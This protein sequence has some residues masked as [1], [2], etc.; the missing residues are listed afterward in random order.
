M[1]SNTKVT[2]TR[3]SAMKLGIAL[4]RGFKTH[5]QETKNLLFLGL[6]I[7]S[8]IIFV[9][10]VVNV[11]DYIFYERHA[12]DSAGFVSLLSNL[13]TTGEMKS[14]IF[15]SFY[16]LLPTLTMSFEEFTSYNFASQYSE[17]SFFRWHAYIISYILSF[18][19][20]VGVPAFTISILTNIVG[21]FGVIFIVIGYC[22]RNNIS[23][24]ITLGITLAFLYFLPIKEVVYG[25]FYF[26]KLFPFFMLWLCVNTQDM[27]DDYGLKK[28]KTLALIILT[29][30]CATI[31]E[32]AALMSGTFLIF[33]GLLYQSNNSTWK[34]RIILVMA[35]LGCI[36]WFLIYNI[37]FYDSLYASSTSPANII[38]NAKRLILDDVFQDKAFVLFQ[39]LIPHI[40]FGL[41]SPLAGFIAVFAVIPNFL[42]DIGGA[43][44]IGFSTHYHMMYL[45][46][47]VF[48]NLGAVKNV[49]NSFSRSKYLLDSQTLKKIG[50]SFV[51]CRRVFNFHGEFD[52]TN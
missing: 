6:W 51:C 36:V 5:A 46:F 11:E 17:E 3:I 23:F 40:I 26:D 34:K 28:S 7:L 45:P 43:E 33:F 25:Q 27:L 18:F 22:Y 9:R 29:I 24:P 4:S 44:K 21:T 41:L 30:V 8:G 15:S 48:A 19:V 10:L 35:G 14:S 50:T 47:I 38:Y 31:S 2:S 49:C 16:S 32:R 20:Y 52:C 1:F 42:I 12:I 37:L 39:V 13:A